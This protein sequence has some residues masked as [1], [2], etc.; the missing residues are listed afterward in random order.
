MR[1]ARR[2][3]VVLAECS[4]PARVDPHSGT[5]WQL[6]NDSPAGKQSRSFDWKALG[7]I[8]YSR[9]NS[10]SPELGLDCRLVADPLVDADCSWLS[11]LSIL[12]LQLRSLRAVHGQ[13]MLL[14]QDGHEHEEPLLLK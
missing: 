5:R 11:F 14:W 2:S 4:K 12:L 1:F 10:G 13:H 8:P 9:S 3:F 7:P 6:L